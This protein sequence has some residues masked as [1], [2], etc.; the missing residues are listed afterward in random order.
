MGEVRF[1]SIKYLD[2][3]VDPNNFLAW[4]INN[5]EEVFAAVENVNWHDLFSLLENDEH[6]VNYV[7]LYE[8]M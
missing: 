5:Y 1:Y 2:R 3:Y 4:N 8:A 6:R 7:D